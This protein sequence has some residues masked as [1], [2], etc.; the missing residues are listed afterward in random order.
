MSKTQQKRGTTAALARANLSSG[1]IA[2][3]LSK[4]TL[5]VYDGARLGGYELAKAD[6]T[7]VSNPNFSS[8]S[9]YLAVPRGATSSTRLANTPAF[10]IRGEAG[11]FFGTID[12][13]TWRA[14]AFE[15]ADDGDTSVIFESF[16]TTALPTTL[17]TALAVWDLDINEPKIGTQVAGQ[18]KRLLTE[19]ATFNATTATTATNATNAE[20]SER[21][22]LAQTANVARNSSGTGAFNLPVGDAAQ[23]Q[24][25]ASGTPITLG[26]IRYLTA[27]SGGR[28]STVTRIVGNTITYTGIALMSDLPA[29]NR[30]VPNSG[31]GFVFRNTDATVSLIDFTIPTAAKL[32]P[33]LTGVSNG[34]VLTARNGV[35]AWE[36]STASTPTSVGSLPYRFN[37]SNPILS[38]NGR[39][40]FNSTIP[41]SI[42]QIILT[43]R[44]RNGSDREDRL[45]QWDDSTNPGHKGTLYIFAD[46]LD[47]SGNADRHIS[48][49]VTRVVGSSS[50]VVID[51]DRT[52]TVTNTGTPFNTNQNIRLS[53]SRTGNAG[54]GTG[55]DGLTTADITENRGSVPSSPA[56]PSYTYRWVG[57]GGNSRPDG[58]I[59]SNSSNRTVAGITALRLSTS[60]T[61][62][63]NLAATIDALTPYPQYARITQG[64]NAVI[65]RLRSM[66]STTDPDFRSFPADYISGSELTIGHATLQFSD[67]QDGFDGTDA[68]P[69]ASISRLLPINARDG[70]IPEFDSATN[71][72]SVSN[73]DGSDT[74]P[75]PA[76]T[77]RFRRVPSSSTVPNTVGSIFLNESN[78]NNSTTSA[79]I[80]INLEDRNGAVIRNLLD[81]LETRFYIRIVSN[82]TTGI[83]RLRT[84]QNQSNRSSARTYIVDKITSLSSATLSFNSGS[85]ADVAFSSSDTFTK[86]VSR[87]LPD[88]DV[89]DGQ[90]A[91]YNAE[92]QEWEA[93]DNLIPILSSIPT[94]TAFDAL[95]EGYKFYNS[96]DHREYVKYVTSF[97]RSPIFTRVTT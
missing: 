55:T 35:S 94:G 34:S 67:T 20:D 44:D 5:N 74:L 56:S 77:Y 26:A 41:A 30:L 24:V 10:S 17:N 33:S 16:R 57:H 29:H 73:K 36:A 65:L 82:N 78:D 83:Y 92:L 75:T 80:S 86:N 70:Q 2:V 48:F 50:N 88:E 9:G 22:V 54:T 93:V 23:G 95:Q 68:R 97:Y 1:E 47:Q 43:R 6:L 64:V 63:T 7:N 71:S 4:G 60:M 90:I 87:L 61:N 8:S 96:S 15:G 51:V 79:S 27:I 18:F 19:G 45:V 32:V 58:S 39:L 53:F 85:T 3:N 72:W 84:G 91:R 81:S 52:Q 40:Y 21:A 28:L 14:F 11:K 62:G 49:A 31:R 42:T 66:A 89:R 76:T 37:G 38:G 69:A 13:S 59:T 12:G 25:A 46:D